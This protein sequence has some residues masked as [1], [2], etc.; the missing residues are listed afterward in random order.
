MNQ[1]SHYYLKRHYVSAGTHIQQQQQQHKKIEIIISFFFIFIFRWCCLLFCFCRLRYRH[2]NNISKKKK[3]KN[4]KCHRD[5]FWA[6]IVI[7]YPICS[8]FAMCVFFFFSVFYMRPINV[9][10]MAIA[11][12]DFNETKR[13]E[14]N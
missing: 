12:V 14:S 10:R 11:S 5:S 13:C 8:K 9:P 4:E 2:S 3:L 7:I 6:L 1:I